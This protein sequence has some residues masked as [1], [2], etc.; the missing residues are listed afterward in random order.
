METIIFVYI[1]LYDAKLGEGKNMDCVA[2]ETLRTQILYTL[3]RE[4]VAT[5]KMEP[6]NTEKIEYLKRHIMTV[7]GKSEKNYN[8]SK[9]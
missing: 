2:I 4:L 8:N 3:L 1:I 6:T 7:S 5:Y 9:K